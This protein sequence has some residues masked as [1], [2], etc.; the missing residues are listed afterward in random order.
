[1]SNKF[2]ETLWVDKSANADEIKKAYRKQ[3]MKYHPDR[4]K[5]DA[6]A[7]KKFKEVNEAYSTLSDPQ[8]KQ[9]YDTFGSAGWNPFGWAGGWAWGFGGFEDMFSGFGWAWAWRQQQSQSFNFEDLFGGW[10]FGWMWGQQQSHRKTQTKQEPVSLD[11]EKTY[12][13]PVFDMILGCK[14]EV[15]WVYGQTAKLKIPANTKPGAKF[16]VK[17]FWKSEGTKKWNLIIKIEALMPKHISDVDL[18]ML[19]AIRENI[20]Y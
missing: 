1:M 16:R 17:D 18:H 11:F 2:Y 20:G 10:G 7:E 15:K 4:N 13:V 14:I 12:E 9:Q 3:A 19:E 6:A 5:G 8:K